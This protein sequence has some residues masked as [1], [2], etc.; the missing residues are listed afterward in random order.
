MSYAEFLT[1]NGDDA[2]IEWVNGKVVRLPGVSSG[3]I[4]L[5]GF[6]TCV[7][8][9]FVEVH[10]LGTIR[11]RPFQMKCHA[12]S[13]GRAPDLFF[14]REARRKRLKKYYMDGPADLVVEVAN[15]ASRKVD[16]HTKF[17]EYQDGGV[18]EYWLIDRGLRRAKFYAMSADRTFVLLPVHRGVFRSRVLDGLWLRVQWLWKPRMPLIGAMKELSLM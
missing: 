11:R 16:G 10:G 13:S 6:L 18:R 12:K 5:M 8:G 3:E 17:R 2:H 15:A 7:L 4:E 14:V 9:L 1:L